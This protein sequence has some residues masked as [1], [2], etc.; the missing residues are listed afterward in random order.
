MFGKLSQP[1][2]IFYTKCIKAFDDP[3]RRSLQRF[4][5]FLAGL[6]GPLHGT[7]G[8]KERAGKRR[9]GEIRGSSPLP[10]IPESASLGAVKSSRGTVA[11]S[12]CGGEYG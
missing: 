11:S 5:N 1:E 2:A 4:P 9:K 10:P 12:L 8:Q 7:E 3:Q 6:K